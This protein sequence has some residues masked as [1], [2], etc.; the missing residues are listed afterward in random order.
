MVGLND[1]ILVALFADLQQAE[2]AAQ[3]LA[4][5]GLSTQGA[6]LVPVPLRTAP[7]APR[8]D[9]GA[10]APQQD[11]SR[12]MAVGATVGGTLGLLA[13]GW[14]SRGVPGGVG[15]WAGTLVGAS[16]GTFLGGLVDAGTD[17]G[18]GGDAGAA[19]AAT[20]AR[21]W[22][23]LVARVSAGAGQRA[24]ELLGSRHPLALRQ[25]AAEDE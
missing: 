3:A 14:V 6:V 16:I 5:S 17:A 22:A 7:A 24:A 15:P 18:D 8:P 19:D 9:G 20:K 1:S 23:G 10:D 21:G 25:I 13:A 11:L 2:A 4:E 12:T